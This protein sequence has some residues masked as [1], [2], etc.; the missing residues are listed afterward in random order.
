[1]A[2][3]GAVFGGKRRRCRGG[4]LTKGIRYDIIRRSVRLFSSAAP[5][6]S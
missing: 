6:E 1:M 2:I 5:R 3:R 4:V